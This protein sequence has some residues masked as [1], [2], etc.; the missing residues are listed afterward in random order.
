MKNDG[1]YKTFDIDF[2]AVDEAINLDFTAIDGAIKQ[3]F[4]AID[5]AIKYKGKKKKDYKI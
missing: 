1:D 4:T 3:D 2:T 5:K